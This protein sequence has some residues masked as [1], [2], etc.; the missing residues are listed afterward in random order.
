MTA[1]AQLL[2]GGGCV[3]SLPLL[4]EQSRMRGPTRERFSSQLPLFLIAAA[5]SLRIFICFQHNPMDYIFS[6]MSRHWNNGIIFP[7][8][9][10]F[11]VGDPIGY[12]VYVWVLHFVTRDNRYL[13]ALASALMSVL[14]PWTFYR[15]SREFGLPKV[16]SRW[17]WALIAA[18][19]SLFVIYHYLMMETLLLLL[20]GI[21]LWMTA[22]YLRK[23]GTQAFLI[24]VIAW[25]LA[26]LTK[27]T[28]GP[29]A[30]VCFLWVWW[31]K[32]TPIRD[33]A[34]AAM[35]AL[36][37]VAP[38]A[39][40]SK[41]KLGFYAPFGNPW[42]T[43]LM[44][45][46]QATS[47]E[48]D[49]FDTN[50]PNGTPRLAIVRST[51]PSCLLQPLKPLSQ[52]QMRRSNTSTISVIVIN[53]AY[54]ELGWK[55]AYQRYSD[56]TDLSEWL[57]QWRENIVLFFFAPSWPESTQG[58]DG[59]LE[60]YGR[61]LWAPLIVL[62]FLLNLKQF[63]NRRFDLIP[64]ITVFFTIF[65]ALQNVFIMEGR[66]RKPLEPLLLLNL[67]WIVATRQTNATDR[68]ELDP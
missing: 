6:D 41:R 30:A 62:T 47:S 42:L 49:L 55:Q 39:V 10:Y 56:H 52:W 8:S 27:P 32:S 7:H 25:T 33:L 13:I 60:Y 28:V 40:R 44:L 31:K 21:A 3:R 57:A 59:Q 34:I 2:R 68:T 11:G 45:R 64:V 9:T 65:L 20:E 18:T 19:P 17:V 54:G 12:Q 43:R 24:F 29:L 67:V 35:I 46:S 61:W 15:A 22:R 48:L 26:V 63:S 58:W 36:L 14:M 38:Q 1:I 5:S 53:S 23:G 37:L 16:P 50:T 66:Y 51:S 4:K